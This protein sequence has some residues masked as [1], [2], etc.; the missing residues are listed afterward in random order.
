MKLL[1]IILTILLVVM[2]LFSF[3]VAFK[4]HKVTKDGYLSFKSSFMELLYS[5]IQLTSEKFMSK[6]HATMFF[7]I[8]A[9]SYGVFILAINA[10]LWLVV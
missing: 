6:R 10:L 1:M 8:I 9:F 3:Y 5:T 7:K 2:A 4:Q